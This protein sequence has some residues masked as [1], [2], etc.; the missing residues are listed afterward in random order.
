MMAVIYNKVA[1]SL[2]SMLL[3]WLLAMVSQWNWIKGPLVI[4]FTKSVAVQ[5]SFIAIDL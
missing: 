1:S 5:A 3:Y 2:F 4:L